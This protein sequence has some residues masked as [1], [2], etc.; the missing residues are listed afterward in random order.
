VISKSDLQCGEVPIAFVVLSDVGI[1]RVEQGIDVKE[2]IAV[3]VQEKLVC[4]HLCTSLFQNFPQ[5]R[6][7]H[8]GSRNSF[9]IH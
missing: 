8:M 2:S 5:G 9:K 6:Y 7:S 1:E 3:H 4:L